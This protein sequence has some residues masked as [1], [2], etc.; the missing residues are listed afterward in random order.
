MTTPQPESSEASTAW[1]LKDVDGVGARVFLLLTLALMLG[2][3]LRY[4]EGVSVGEYLK[5]PDEILQ[6]DPGYFLLTSLF[7]HLGIPFGVFAFLFSAFWVGAKAF[8]MFRLSNAPLLS[9]VIY[10][11]TFYPLQELIQIRAGA[12]SGML[13]LGLPSLVHGRRLA[14]VG[15]LLAAISFHYSAIALLPLAFMRAEAERPRVYLAVLL[16][17]AALAA[18]GLRL[19]FHIQYLESM[20]IG[21]R[22]ALYALDPGG[23]LAAPTAFNRVSIPNLLL[24]VVLLLKFDRVKQITP[25]ASHVVRIFAVSQIVYLLLVQGLPAFAFRLSE[26]F[27]IVGVL[28]WPLLLGLVRDEKFQLATFALVCLN[29]GMSAAKL[30]P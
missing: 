11:C 13:L 28:A 6:K 10:A 22:I 2:T 29:F 3:G 25:Y 17:S 7:N 16:A 8:Q 30:F 24:A 1:G 15:M 5:A 23:E 18:S 4:A 20:D 9:I 21:G 12:A 27:G 14:F 26:L 19:D